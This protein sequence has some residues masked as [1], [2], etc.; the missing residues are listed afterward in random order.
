MPA[1]VVLGG[2]RHQVLSPDAVVVRRRLNA[3]PACVRAA[4]V[5]PHVVGALSMGRLGDDGWF[6]TT[7][8]PVPRELGSL[9]A[10]GRA[11]LHGTGVRA[12]LHSRVEIEVTAWPGACEISVHPV[13]R[14]PLRWGA[15]RLRRY[16]DLAPRF[17]DRLCSTLIESIDC[18]GSTSTPR[19]ALRE[20]AAA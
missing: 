18:A 8:H 13:A 2:G 16:L 17:T 4:L 3:D 20:Q 1:Q 6:E 11:R 10:R 7:R 15:R 5:D 9:V 12:V 19:P 14:N